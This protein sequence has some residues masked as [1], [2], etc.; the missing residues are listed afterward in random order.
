MMRK[1]II[2]TIFLLLFVTGCY[3]YMQQELEITVGKKRIIKRDTTTIN[4]RD[5]LITDTLKTIN[6]DE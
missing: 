4:S 1:T 2:S 6:Y 5:T 3:I